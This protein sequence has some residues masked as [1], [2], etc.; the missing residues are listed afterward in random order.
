ML[1]VK[2]VVRNL[3]LYYRDISNVVFSFLGMLISLIIYILFLKNNLVSSFSYLDNASEFIDLWMISGLISIVAVTSSLSGFEQMIDDKNSQKIKDFIINS[4]INKKMIGFLYL[5][6]AF[7]E[8]V[9]STFIFSLICFIYL[10]AQYTINIPV[11]NIFKI[12]ICMLLLI[13][14]STLLFYLIT[15]FIST[16]SSF[17]SFSALIGTVTGFLSGS[18]IIVGELPKLMR[19]FLDYWPG[20]GLAAIIRSNLCPIDHVPHLILKKLGI[21]D[22]NFPILLTCIEILA[23]LLIIYGKLNILK[24]LNTLISKRK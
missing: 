17:A 9:I 24:N 2:F 10:K 15:N 6:T 20:F 23:L 8:A 22:S 1:K 3:I 4:K 16:N 13:I 7:I 18:Y 12:L 19:K 5:I 14:F 21:I 11:R